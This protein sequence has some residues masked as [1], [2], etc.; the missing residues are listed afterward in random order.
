MFKVILN[1]TDIR[2]KYEAF[3][4]FNDFDD[5]FLFYKY[6]L[7]PLQDVTQSQFSNCRIDLNSVFFF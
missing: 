5:T 6:L 4:C 7:Y 1:L 3:T 2:T